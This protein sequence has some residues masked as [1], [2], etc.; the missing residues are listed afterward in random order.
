[1]SVQKI[2][3]AS[4]WVRDPCA[5]I[6]HQ[7]SEYAAHWQRNEIKG[8]DVQNRIQDDRCI[9]AHV[10]NIYNTLAIGILCNRYTV[11]DIVS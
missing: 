6:S 4:L 8:G 9:Y 3:L 7:S 10:G 5:D 2:P 1:M 11:K